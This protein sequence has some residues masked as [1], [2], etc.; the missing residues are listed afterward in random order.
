MDGRLF[1]G[2]LARHIA[3]DPAAHRGFL[4]AHADHRLHDRR[5]VGVEEERLRRGVSCLAPHFEPAGDHI[6]HHALEG[7]ERIVRTHRAAIPAHHIGPIR[8]RPHQRV[9]VGEHFEA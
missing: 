7:E 6:R 8:D 9:L 3:S 2:G 5:T 1:G 4:G